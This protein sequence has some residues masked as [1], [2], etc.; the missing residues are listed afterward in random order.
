[1]LKWLACWLGVDKPDSP[2][3]IAEQA[4]DPE[5][6]QRV[7]AAKALAA[8]PEPWASEQLLGL[9]KDAVDTVRD[10]A[11]EALRKQG[12]AAVNALLKALDHADPKIAVYAAERLGELKAPDAIRPLLL[13]LKFGAVE[14]RAA[15][16]RALIDYGSAAIAAL[17]AARTDPDP[18]T[19]LRV[20]EI[21]SAIRV[22]TPTAETLPGAPPEITGAADLEKGG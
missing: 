9:L 21:L 2:R 1:M 11:R 8:V 15:S 16:I 22:A 20:D 19:R 3:A 5:P 14:V 13:T 7:R 6:E 10:A 18:W 17:E 4:S 12:A